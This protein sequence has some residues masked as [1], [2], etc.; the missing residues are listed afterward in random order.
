MHP[1]D[2]SG[3]SGSSQQHAAI[4]D[5]T[6]A[7]QDPDETLPA[8]GAGNIT[9]SMSGGDISDLSQQLSAAVED[10]AAA[11]AASSA[12][13]AADTALTAD[14]AAEDG[15]TAKGSVADASVADAADGGSPVGTP[16]GE[17]A[18]LPSAAEEET[19]AV[20]NDADAVSSEGPCIGAADAE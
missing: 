18:L 9:A 20:P 16:G 11:A 15:A 8:A 13:R 12:E 2:T 17:A 10:A 1:E 6:A 5:S 7:V 3:G 4:V 14:A 19:D